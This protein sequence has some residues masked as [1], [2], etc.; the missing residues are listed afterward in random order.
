MVTKIAEF[1]IFSTF[2]MLTFHLLHLGYLFFVAVYQ[3]TM[4]HSVEIY[5]IF[6]LKK[7]LRE[8]NLGKFTAT[9]YAILTA[10]Y[11]SRVGH[12]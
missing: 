11:L 6:Y 10:K 2:P 5:G 8:I 3:Q 9:K 7:F 1:A 4:M 12:L